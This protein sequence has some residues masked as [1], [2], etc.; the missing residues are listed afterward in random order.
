VN[1][2]VGPKRLTSKWQLSLIPKGLL[3]SYLLTE[4]GRAHLDLPNVG[5]VTGISR[6]GLLEEGLLN[7]LRGKVQFNQARRNRTDDGT[8][9]GAPV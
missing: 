4:Q 2:I 1:P 6:G 7:L 3:S 5:A 8:S 9:Y